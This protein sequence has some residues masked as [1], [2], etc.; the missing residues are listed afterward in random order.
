MNDAR[1]DH[2]E[3][4]LTQLSDK[5]DG[6]SLRMVTKQDLETSMAKAFE[7][8]QGGFE[9][10]RGFMELTVAH[11]VGAL[12]TDMNQRFDKVDARFDRL[13][14]LIKGR[15]RPSRRRPRRRR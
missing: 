12:R 5:V 7:Q 11:H 4:T 10:H 6:L 14:T 2:I 13:E 9:D 1:V 3:E 15:P 8:T